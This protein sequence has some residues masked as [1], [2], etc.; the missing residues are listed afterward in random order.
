MGSSLFV[1]LTQV[2]DATFYMNVLHLASH[3]FIYLVIIPELCPA[4]P[5]LILHTDV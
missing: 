5:V 2:P 4:D 1:M 3:L